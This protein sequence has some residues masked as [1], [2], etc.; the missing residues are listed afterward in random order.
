M[1]KYDLASSSPT[2]SKTETFYAYSYNRPFSASVNFVLPSRTNNAFVL[3][4]KHFSCSSA[5]QLRTNSLLRCERLRLRSTKSAFFRKRKDD[6]AGGLSSQ[7]SRRH[8]ETRKM[9]TVLL[10]TSRHRALSL[11]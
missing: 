3:F 4:A 9:A 2:S 8:I 11:Y 1:D 10:R 6:T 5:L 7:F